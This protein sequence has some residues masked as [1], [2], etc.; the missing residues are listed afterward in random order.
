M[1]TL[2]LQD[3]TA[4]SV[5]LIA[6]LFLVRWFTTTQTQYLVRLT[7]QIEVLTLTVLNMQSFLIRHDAQTRGVDAFTGKDQAE[8]DRVAVQVYRQTQK[9]LQDLTEIIKDLIKNRH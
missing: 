7:Q 1:N 3:L 2:N 5:I 8:R 4:Y 6:F 9:E